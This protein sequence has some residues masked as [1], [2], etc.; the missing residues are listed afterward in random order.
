[1]GGTEPV[2]KIV[3][4]ILSK[5]DSR[6]GESDAGGYELSGIYRFNL[7]LSHLNR[8]VNPAVGR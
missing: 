2:V 8:N 1:M 3:N 4:G 6:A 7:L 5:E